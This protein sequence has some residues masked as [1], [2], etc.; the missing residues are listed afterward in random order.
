[1]KTAHS[2]ITEL[3]VAIT[4][5]A[6]CLSNATALTT[7]AQLLNGDFNEGRT[8]FS[9]DYKFDLNGSF[10][11]GYYTIQTNSQSANYNYA[12]FGDHTTG[13]GFM[14]LADGNTNINRA[15][16]SQTIPTVANTPYAFSAW[17]ASADP[18]SP[19]VLRFLANGAQLGSDLDLTANSGQWEQFVATWISGSNTQVSLA[20][21]DINQSYVGNDFALDDLAF[22]P[23]TNSVTGVKAYPAIELVWDSQ[24]GSIYQVQYSTAQ[25]PQGWINLG[26]PIKTTNGVANLL[27]S[28][29]DQPEKIYRVLLL[30]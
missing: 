30:K 6:I 10:L 26:M 9:S 11:P 25:N 7:R 12:K 3:R 28:T 5:L 20:I 14:L 15:I 2:I 22:T 1:M 23:A 17:A 13:K 24:P 18:Q 29:R 8:N 19:A 21:V 4:L 16:W 27:N